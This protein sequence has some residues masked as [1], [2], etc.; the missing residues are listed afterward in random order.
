M[1]A[2]HRYWVAEGLRRHSYEKFPTLTPT[3]PRGPH[4]Q[5]MVLYILQLLLC[6]YK[7]IYIPP[8]TQ[9]IARCPPSSALC[10]LSDRAELS[11]SV[12]E[13]TPL[14]ASH[15]MDV[16]PHTGTTSLLLGD[17]YA[18]ANTT[19]LQNYSHLRPI[20]WHQ[21]QG[22]VAVLKSG[23]PTGSHLFPPIRN[24]ELEMS[25]FPPKFFQKFF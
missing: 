16:P 10:F 21:A 5:E 20:D 25:P 19:R 8:F 22:G 3:P 11:P 6:K 1:N 12:L 7:Q 17:S 18:V 24:L 13:S 4:P 9:R 2:S 15:C 14:D 23:F